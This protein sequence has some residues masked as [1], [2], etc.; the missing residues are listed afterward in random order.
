M[1]EIITSIRCKKSTIKKLREFEIH[2]RETN[3]EIIIR[4][5]KNQGN[6]KR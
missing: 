6:K 4:L 3:E 2:F 5:I 1:S